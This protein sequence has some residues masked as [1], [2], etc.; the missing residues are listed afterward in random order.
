MGGGGREACMCG[1]GPRTNIPSMI[2]ARVVQRCFF[3]NRTDVPPQP[4]PHTLTRSH[5]HT[6][7]LLHS[8]TVTLTHS[9]SP[10]LSHS[11]TLTLLH[12]QTLTL[13]RSPI[14]K[15]NRHSRLVVEGFHHIASN[16]HQARDGRILHVTETNMMRDFMLS[17]KMRHHAIVA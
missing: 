17:E 5:S 14:S 7:T 12:S 13:S 6:L 3:E 16:R 4:C 1:K 15:T 10:T 2:S 11:H 9:H 8:H